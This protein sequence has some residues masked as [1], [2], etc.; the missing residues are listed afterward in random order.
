MRQTGKS[1]TCVWRWHERFAATGFEGLLREKN[2][3]GPAGPCHRAV[4][5]RQTQA[6]DRT[7]PGL[8]HEEGKA[9]PMTHY[10][11]RNGTTTLFA[12]LNVLDGSAART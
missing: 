4:S 9:R 5:R 12:A 2:L 7:Q 11:K 3:C 1:K 10:Y 8:P 6:L